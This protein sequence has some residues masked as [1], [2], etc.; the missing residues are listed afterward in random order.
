MKKRLLALILCGMLLLSGCTSML[1]RSYVSGEAHVDYTV[2][3]DASILRA[4]TYQGLVNAM[5]Y[6]V[7]EHAATGTIR[8]Y[9][10]TGDVEADLANACAVVC[11]EDPLGA[12]AVR[13]IQY[14]STRILTY[15]EVDLRIIYSRTEEVTSAI[16]EVTGVT[17]LRQELSRMVAERQSRA[18][19]LVSYFA[20]DAQVVDTLFRLALYS[21]PDKVIQPDAV[22]C[23]ATFYPGVGTRSIIEVTIDWGEYDHAALESYSRQ[24]ADAGIR[25]L[26]ASPPAGRHYAVAELAAIV[27]SACPAYDGAGANNG[28]G[29]LSGESSDDLALLLAMEYLCQQVGIEATMV[30]GEGGPWLIVSTSRGYRHLLPQSLHPGFI[31]S[32]QQPL[33]YT[34]EELLALGGYAWEDGL[35]PACI[36]YAMGGE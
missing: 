26:E 34:D 22:T 23:T 31:D 5:L 7:S 8:L 2:A 27:R 20:G 35:Y 12:F 14:D 19:F 17:G 6:F 16:R 21:T 3:E 18:A 32:G 4:E 10:Y 15:Y 13:S 9:N 28:L 24:L 36:R 29:A 30:L 1:E 25:L 11:G 33:L